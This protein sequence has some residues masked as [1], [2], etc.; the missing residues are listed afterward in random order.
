MDQPRL[1]DDLT[2]AVDVLHASMTW[3]WPYGWKVHLVW[4][5]SGEEGFHSATF[6][7]DDAER[8]VELLH[9]HLVS[10]LGLA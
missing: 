5:R 8:A 4:R 10:V 9:H 7:S 6:R 1:C 3:E 2:Y